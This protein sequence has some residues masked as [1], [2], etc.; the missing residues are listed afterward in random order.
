MDHIK[1][2]LNRVGA[3]DLTI[4]IDK[5]EATIVLARV[6]NPTGYGLVEADSHGR[7][8]RFTEKPAE[9]EVT[10]DT[11]N[12]GIYVLER[13]I[14]NRISPDGPQSF[15]RDVFPQ[16]LQD[17]ARF[18]AYLNRGYWQDIGSPSKYL[19]AHYGIISGR[20]K[21]P[22]YPHRASAPIRWNKNEVQIDS[23]SM[24]E[25]KCVI[26]PGV[27]IENSVLGEECRIEEG[28]L[29]KD[30]VIWSG[31]RVRS[32]AR[33]ERAIIG[34][35]CHIEEHAIVERSIIWANTRISQEAIVR[36]SI[37]GRHCH[38]GKYVT[39]ENGVVLGDKSVLTDYCRL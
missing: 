31:T 5:A 36:H 39:I 32:N 14:L 1:V 30:S 16:L 11:I 35:Q 15:E 7:V 22:A 26:K 4:P 38:I 6:M 33:V 29:I 21:L 27:T 12:A 23:Y 9:D 3:K 13:S 28:A 19:E 34:R 18:Y 8:V 10:G 20:M 17:G 24:L 37:L 25:S 2:V